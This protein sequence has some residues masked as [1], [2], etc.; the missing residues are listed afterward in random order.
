[1]AKDAY[2][3]YLALAINDKEKNKVDILAAANYL[4][5]YYVQM[6]ENQNEKAK[7]ELASGTTYTMNSWKTYCYNKA[8]ENYELVLSLDP[9]DEDAKH[10]I[11]LLKEQIKTIG[12]R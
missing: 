5:Y 10:Y 4:A 12:G 9:T 3:K 7:A 8:I 11:E 6:A 2:E 1:M